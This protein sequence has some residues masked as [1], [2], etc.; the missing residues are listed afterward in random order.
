MDI[1]GPSG[2]M[3]DPALQAQQRADA[4]REERQRL[5]EEIR[6]KG[7]RTY[8]D[9]L[10][11]EKMEELRRK[12]LASMGLTEEDLAKMPA[13]QRAAIEKAISEEI[14]KRLAA[15]NLT[16]N[17]AVGALGSTQ[18]PNGSAAWQTSDSDP[19]KPDLLAGLARFDAA[20]L[21]VFED[22]ERSS[23]SAGNQENIAGFGR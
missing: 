12:I 21:K 8:V 2:S 15:S 13:D 6:E 3:Y 18:Q 9:D 10:E 22:M 5:L 11:K 17:D 7:F 23:T 20:I 19:M 4:G 16:K 1:I 14:Q